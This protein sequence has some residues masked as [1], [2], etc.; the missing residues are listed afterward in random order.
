MGQSTMTIQFFK[1][2]SAA[3]TMLLE[4]FINCYGF[5]LIETGVKLYYN[6]RNYSVKFF[7]ILYSNIVD[8]YRNQH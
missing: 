4:L 8:F 6:D 2:I 3:M 5:N 1:L 7:Q